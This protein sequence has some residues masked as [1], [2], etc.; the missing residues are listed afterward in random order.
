[1]KATKSILKEEDVL[2]LV[3]SIV[4]FIFLSF[5]LVKTFDMIH[6]ESERYS[7][8]PTFSTTTTVTLPNVGVTQR[9]T[10][11]VKHLE[12]DRTPLQ[13]RMA[14][15]NLYSQMVGKELDL[16]PD[17]IMAVIET[18]S[19]YTPDILG[20]GAVGLMQ[21]IPSCHTANME[22]YGYS[23]QDLTDPYK[24]IRVGATYLSYLT[25]KY[26]DISFALTC[27]NKGE[28]GALSTGSKTS[29]YSDEVMKVYN[30]L[31]GGDIY[32]SQS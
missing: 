30:R 29:Y 22:K 10:L 9:K 21:L 15:C 11:E 31:K 4:S 7:V 20:G 24:N 13:K 17:L 16:D 26:A 12:D 18:E 2:G 6:K 25:H 1:M 8:H 19:Q 28:G 5:V 27:Y 32:G 3:L 23:V 14:K